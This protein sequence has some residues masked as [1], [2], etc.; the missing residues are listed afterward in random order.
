VEKS[1][2]GDLLMIRLRDGE[3]LLGGL[4]EALKEE[5]ISS[6]VIIGGVGMVRGAAISFYV[7][8]GE[9]QT[10]PV[11]DAVELCSMNGNISMSDGELRLHIHV[12]VAKRGGVV[13]G[14]HLS[15]GT[16]N[17]TAE[18]GVLVAGQKMVRKLDPDTGLKTLKF[19]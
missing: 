10:R 9:Y 5:G 19:E 4:S 3:D 14:G 18:I 7:G 6:G 11:V 16:V 17:M 13:L 1:R 15:A 2:K 12:T 8:K